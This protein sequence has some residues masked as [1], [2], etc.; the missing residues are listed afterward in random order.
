MQKSESELFFLVC[1]TRVQKLNSELQARASPSERS[2][3]HRVFKLLFNFLYCS[4]FDLQS[5]LFFCFFV[6]FFSV[7]LLFIK[8]IFV[9]FCKYIIFFLNEPYRILKVYC[10]N[11]LCSLNKFSK[12][13]IA[14]LYEYRQIN[15]QML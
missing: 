6:L 4:S 5:T 10:S 12:K 14:L 9:S 1:P 15:L 7:S 13:T 3:K 2:A 8:D 11:C